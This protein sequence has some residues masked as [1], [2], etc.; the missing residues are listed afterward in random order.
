MKHKRNEKGNPYEVRF[1]NRFFD[2]YF[3]YQH[4]RI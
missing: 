2:G 3:Q 4:R 1:F